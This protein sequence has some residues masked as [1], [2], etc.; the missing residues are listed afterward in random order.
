MGINWSE[1]NFWNDIRNDRWNPFFKTTSSS[2]TR[3][4]ASSLNAGIVIDLYFRHDVLIGVR[5]SLSIYPCGC[6]V[7]SFQPEKSES[8][9]IIRWNYGGSHSYALWNG[10][11]VN[12]T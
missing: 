10:I 1:C 12:T 11:R 9:S 4:E 5:G 3:I 2:S 6:I 7:G 8:S